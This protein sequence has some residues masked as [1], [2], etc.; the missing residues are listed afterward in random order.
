M[1]NIDTKSTKMS[2]K[3]LPKI[4]FLVLGITGNL[5][6]L[7]ILP[8]IGQFTALHGQSFDINLVGYSRS[9]ADLESIKK[10]L[11]EKSQTLPN[12]KLEQGQYDN[13]DVYHKLV[14]ELGSQDR[15]IVYL[16]VPPSVY[17]DFVES[18]CLLGVKQVDILIEKPFGEDKADAQKI[19]ST[20]RK[21]KIA[22]NVHFI[23]HYLFKGACR[24][25]E[26]EVKSGVPQDFFTLKKEIKS[27]K[28][29]ALETLGIAGRGGYYD[30]IGA[31]RDMLVHLFSL[32]KL[33][34]RL[35]GESSEIKDFEIL[36]QK[37][38]QYKGY[39]VDSGVDGSKTETYFEVLSKMDLGDLE[40]IPVT[41]ESGKKQLSKITDITIE[42]QSSSI[43]FEIAP[44]PTI[45]FYS[46]QNLIRT[47]PIK[48][49]DKLDHVNVFEDLITEHY[50]SF[51]DYETVMQGWELIEMVVGWPSVTN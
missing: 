20:I 51:V 9:Q 33:G 21:C 5:A 35:F 31:R 18:S 1:N 44:S 34:L 16:A 40:N 39:V 8:A 46:S 2:P 4:S 11:L 13:F 38:E 42:F 37:L 25:S 14:D 26:S 12:I 48:T 23:D 45:K 28:V 3:T 43:V 32:L 47:I 50:Y 30:G 17:E 36:S 27:I 15:L 7:K 22:G 24:I 29:R 49:T 10:S 6:W 19:L 41:F